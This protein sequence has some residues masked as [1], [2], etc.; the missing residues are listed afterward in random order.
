MVAFPRMK[1]KVLE[2]CLHSGD[3]PVPFFRIHP[4][5]CLEAAVCCLLTANTSASGTM[6]L[7]SRDCLARDARLT[8][9][10]PQPVSVTDV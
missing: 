6:K 7:V 2:K 10:K 3:R 5:G 9:T 1:K 8:L 4:E